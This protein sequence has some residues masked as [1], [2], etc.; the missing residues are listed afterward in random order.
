MS[1]SM[2]AVSLLAAVA[3]STEC[4][5]AGLECLSSTSESDWQWTDYG[6]T[7]RESVSDC[8]WLGLRGS[9]L[10]PE[11]GS[12]TMYFRLGAW[13]FNWFEE[14]KA[15]CEFDDTT[16]TI[17]APG[18]DVQ[19]GWQFQV[20]LYAGW[21]YSFF[22]RTTKVLCQ[23]S[24]GLHQRIEGGIEQRVNA[25]TCETCRLSGCATT[26]HLRTYNCLPSPSRSVSPSPTSSRSRS[27]SP[28][29]SG[30]FWPSG[31]LQRTSSLRP[32]APFNSFSGCL[33]ESEDVA[34]SLFNHTAL[35]RSDGPLASTPSEFSGGIL[36]SLLRNGTWHFGDS[37]LFLD[38][39]NA[40]ASGCLAESAILV[41]G[42]SMQ[43]SESSDIFSELPGAS[44]AFVLSSH[45]SNSI[46]FDRSFSTRLG[47]SAAHD[48]SASPRSM[49]YLASASCADTS[50][51]DSV[52]WEL[53]ALLGRSAVLIAQSREFINS[54]PLREVSR[55]RGSLFTAAVVIGAAAFLLAALLVCIVMRKR[56]RKMTISSSSDVEADLEIP[57]EE[58]HSFLDPGD[59]T[60]GLEFTPFQDIW[61]TSTDDTVL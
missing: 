42:T 18:A 1:M 14:T 15:D 41:A 30:E 5:T 47:N 36:S 11:T 3:F 58:P 48:R 9:F 13:G 37:G 24:V 60:E 28:T 27:P 39:V 50:V 2:F 22:I 6:Q 55:A 49:V 26:A 51:Y 53:S 10:P 19:Q 38:S 21:R 45:L 25:D 40:S 52:V 20:Y 44:G 32:S 35:P 12:Y 17:T 56:R 7:R 31:G 23:A 8:R 61:Q 4:G 29:P 33:N 46:E 57:A 43:F 16:H 54:L 34:A 59:I